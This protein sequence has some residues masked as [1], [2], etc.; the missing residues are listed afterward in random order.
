[1][2][3]YN[4]KIEFGKQAKKFRIYFGLGQKQTADLSFMSLS[5]YSDLENGKT[6]Y[7]VEKIQN[8]SSI[9]GLLYYHMGNPTCKFPAFAKLP[10]ETQSVINNREEPLR[11]YNDR[12]IVEH[13][14]DIF[15]AM[16][17]GTEFLIKNINALIQQKFKISYENEEISGTIN[18]KFKD[19]IHKTTKKDTTK[20][21][22]GAKPFYYQVIKLIT[23]EMAIK[24]K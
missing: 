16:P 9:Y 5:E 18:K 4:I 24:A 3:D 11:I 17:E 12:L 6:N 1:M 22:V 13:L 14:A 19:F 10:K 8:V 20:G 15:S 21:G 2:S 7:N 23:I